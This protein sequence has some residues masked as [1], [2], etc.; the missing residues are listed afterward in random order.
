VELKG[1]AQNVVILQITGRS[2]F[3]ANVWLSMQVK[4]PDQTV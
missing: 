4:I 3:Y 2:P 1:A